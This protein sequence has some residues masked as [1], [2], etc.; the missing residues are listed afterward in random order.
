MTKGLANEDIA[1]AK[2]L[3]LWQGA[4][5]EFLGFPLGLNEVEL[6][7]EMNWARVCF[8][9]SRIFDDQA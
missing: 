3:G 4:G 2:G 9:L 1:S 7:R 6:A 5:V 8:G